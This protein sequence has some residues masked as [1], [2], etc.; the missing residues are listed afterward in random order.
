MNQKQG[1]TLV[2]RETDTRD[3]F[4]PKQW[5]QTLKNTEWVQNCLVKIHMAHCCFFGE[6]ADGER[7]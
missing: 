2:N 4:P 7:R 6:L 5:R 3:F 1:N